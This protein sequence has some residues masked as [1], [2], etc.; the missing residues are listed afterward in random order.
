MSEFVISYTLPDGMKCS[1]MT[2][3]MATAVVHWREIVKKYPD[4][5]ITLI[6]GGASYK[7]QEPWPYE[8]PP[9]F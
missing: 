2:M 6:Y 1:D 8:I 7:K 5:N 9:R 3:D 4:C